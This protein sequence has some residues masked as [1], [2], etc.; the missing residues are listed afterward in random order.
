MSSNKTIYLSPSSK[1]GKKWMVLVDGKTVHFGAEGYE[2]YTIHKDPE[3][4]ERYVNRH[5]AKENWNKSG[6]ATPG[7]WSRWL[8]WN[9]PSFNASLKD[10]EKRFKVKIIKS[11]KPFK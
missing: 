4:M 3:R 7:F 11:S 1:K 6:I 9:K 2:D 10:I 8:I 5:K